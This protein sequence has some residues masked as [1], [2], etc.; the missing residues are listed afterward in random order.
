MDVIVD[1]ILADIITDVAR[2]VR[3]AQKAQIFLVFA[4]QIRHFEDLGIR[5]GDIRQFGTVPVC[6]H[7]LS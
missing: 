1:L 3:L 6:C 7:Q 5:A 4:V 2:A